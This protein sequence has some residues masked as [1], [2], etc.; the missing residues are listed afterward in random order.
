[1][2]PSGRITAL[3][4]AFAAVAATVRT[5][6]ANAKGSPAALR[7][8]MMSRMSEPRSTDQILAR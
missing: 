4:P 8:E 7:V 3:A 2:V 6:V 1:M 5:T